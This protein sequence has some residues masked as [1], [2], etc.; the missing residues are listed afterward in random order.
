LKSS[1]NWLETRKPFV[2]ITLLISPRIH[3]GLPC[4]LEPRPCSKIEHSD[5]TDSWTG[6]QSNEKLN[7]KSISFLHQSRDH[8]KPGTGTMVSVLANIIQNRFVVLFEFSLKDFHKM[9]WIDVFL[10]ILT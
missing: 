1:Q 8:S 5:A 6:R 9:V 2:P 10:N 7:S 4:R 3:S